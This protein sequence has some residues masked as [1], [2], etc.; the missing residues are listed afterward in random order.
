MQSRRPLDAFSQKISRFHEC[1]FANSRITKKYSIFPNSRTEK[2]PFSNSR[3]L[4]G[5]GALQKNS[6]DFMDVKGL[7]VAKIE[8]FPPGWATSARNVFVISGPEQ[9]EIIILWKKVFSFSHHHTFTHLYCRAHVFWNALW[10]TLSWSFCRSHIIRVKALLTKKNHVL[11][12]PLFPGDYVRRLCSASMINNFC[13]NHRLV[14]VSRGMATLGSSHVGW[15]SWAINLVSRFSL[16]TSRFSFLAFHISYPV[17]RF[18]HLVSLHTL[19][20]QDETENEN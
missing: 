7:K 9:K 19:I 10:D 2:G 16:F 14:V 20:C 5:R 8:N 4:G 1:H 17:S 12:T 6:N 11:C 18:S 15:Q 3:T 13:V